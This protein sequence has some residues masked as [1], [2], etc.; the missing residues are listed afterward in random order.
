[1]QLFKNYFIILL[2]NSFLFSFSNKK[3]IIY[4]HYNNKIEFES[5]SY[6]EET[7]KKNDILNINVSAL[8]MISVTPFKR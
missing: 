6:I 2:F 8:D 7:I 5:K 4:F 3:N 1:M